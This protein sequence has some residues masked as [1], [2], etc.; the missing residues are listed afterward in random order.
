MK[1]IRYELKGYGTENDEIGVKRIRSG[2]KNEI[3][4]ILFKRDYSSQF[5]TDKEYLHTPPP[6]ITLPGHV[7]PSYSETWL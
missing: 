5:E 7:I 4:E 6:A 3:D 2:S 1:R